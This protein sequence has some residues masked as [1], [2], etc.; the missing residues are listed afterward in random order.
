MIIQHCAK[1]TEFVSRI[2]DHFY[3]RHQGNGKLIDISIDL[4]MRE[5]ARMEAPV[6]V[7][8]E[9]FCDYRSTR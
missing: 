7:F 4:Y 1:G 9:K 3:G 5:V 6:E 2:G 8:D